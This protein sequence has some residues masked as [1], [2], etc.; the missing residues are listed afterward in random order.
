[1]SIAF[2][3]FL[4]TCETQIQT[5]QNNSVIFTAIKDRKLTRF[6]FASSLLFLLT[7]E[8]LYDGLE[9]VNKLGLYISFEPFKSQNEDP[10]SGLQEHLTNYDEE[11]KK[12]LKQKSEETKQSGSK[13]KERKKNNENKQN[14]EKQ[15]HPQ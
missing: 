8:L 4:I 12:P 10:K 11:K 9:W 3:I 5:T 13:P 14:L 2:S 6:K 7:P 15:T 1:M